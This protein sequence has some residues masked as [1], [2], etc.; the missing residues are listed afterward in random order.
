MKARG[1]LLNA[2]KNI[3]YGQDTLAIIKDDNDSSWKEEL[4]VEEDGRDQEQCGQIASKTGQKW[5]T[6]TVSELHK[7]VFLC[8]YYGLEGWVTSVALNFWNPLSDAMILKSL[9]IQSTGIKII[10]K[11]TFSLCVCYMQLLYSVK[12][13]SHFKWTYL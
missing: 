13:Q 12:I 1:S 6:R 3:W 5:N 7:L 11:I 9:D 8:K 2:I 10:N 4:M